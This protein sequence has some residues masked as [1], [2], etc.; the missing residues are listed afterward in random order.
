MFQATAGPRLYLT[1]GHR[2]LF[3]VVIGGFYHQIDQLI[4]GSEQN[5]QGIEAN[6]AFA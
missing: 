5:D 6:R 2:H 3:D 4:G 1:D